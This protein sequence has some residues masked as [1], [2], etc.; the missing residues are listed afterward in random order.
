VNPLDAIRTALE[1]LCL[2]AGVSADDGGPVAAAA[3]RHALAEL[4]HPV[5]VAN[6]HDPLACGIANYLK[7]RT[8]VAG[9]PYLGEAFLLVTTGYVVLMG[10]RSAGRRATSL[11][12]LPAPVAAALG[13]KV[14][15]GGRKKREAA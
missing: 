2:R 9:L 6:Q 8:G 10:E 12:P 15:R 3:V 5:T 13:A 7:E 11:I 4:G 14:S 1:A